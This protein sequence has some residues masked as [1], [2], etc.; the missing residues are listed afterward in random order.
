MLL[1]QAPTGPYFLGS[2]FSLADVAIAPFLIRQE[3]TRKGFLNGV[4]VEAFTKYP[5]VKEWV[6][7]ILSRPSVKASYPGDEYIN[8]ATKN[9]MGISSL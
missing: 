7:G 3:A 9:R 4:E 2:Q 6:E 5:R 1:E 8:N